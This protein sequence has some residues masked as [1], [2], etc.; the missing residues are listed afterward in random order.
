GAGE[1]AILGFF[2]PKGGDAT[3]TLLAPDGTVRG[4]LR[5]T[6]APNASQEFNPAASAFGVAPEPGDVVRLIVN[7]GGIEAY[8]NVLD[9][10]TND[11]AD[12]PPIAASAEALIPNVGTLLG[13]AAKNF[14]SDLFLSNPD[15]S[16]TAH[17]TITFLPLGSG[18]TP[19]LA[20]LT[21]PPGQS[22]A[23]TDV[24]PTLFSVASGQGTLGIE[25]DVPVVASRRVAARTNLGD[26]ATFAP[27]IDI[28]HFIPDGG[29]AFAFGAPQT[30]TRRT[31][32]LLY[33]H[34]SAGQATVIGYNG[35]GTQVGRL[36]VSMGA[37][38]S[39]RV[40]SVFA[41]FGIFDQAAGKIRVEVTPGMQVFAETAEV[42]IGGDSE[43]FPLQA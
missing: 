7:S 26:Y 16:N 30:S 39:A 28:A 41:H 36:T 6:L 4:T 1:T 37:K 2:S 32:L 31:H 23:I 10:H 29:A 21:L 11:V 14:V 40:D 8:V 19:Q 13:Q 35:A 25:S 34:G 9:A 17:L 18:T 38:E 5:E 43:Y 20:T 12:C 27:A 33:N 24:L 42:D 15:G 3:A 22:R